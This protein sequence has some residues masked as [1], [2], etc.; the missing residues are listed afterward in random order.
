M[1]F[2]GD[3]FKGQAVPSSDPAVKPIKRI[4]P[5]SNVQFKEPKIMTHTA[6]PK[7]AP[8]RGMKQYDMKQ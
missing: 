2:G 6:R 1:R 3:T 5:Q 8:E 7:T 4:K